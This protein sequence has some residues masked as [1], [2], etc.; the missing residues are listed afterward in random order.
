MNRLIL[1]VLVINLCPFFANA[2]VD[3]T[4]PLR[5]T[6]AVAYAKSAPLTKLAAV[7]S[8]DKEDA[9]NAVHEVKNKLKFE[10]WLEVNP[11]KASPNVQT[12]MGSLQ[13]RG[14]VQG[15]AGQGAT[16]SFPP[17]T[18]GDVSESHFIQ[19]V[20]SKYNVYDKLGNKLLGPLNLS[21]LWSQL[22]GPWQGTNDGDPI[23]LYDEEADR[24][25]ITQF[26]VF[27]QPKY[28]LFAISETNDP[29]GAY[30]LYSFSF[31]MMNDYPKIGVWID[32]YYATYNMHNNGFQGARITVVERDRML[33]G[34]PAAQMIEFHRSNQASLM[35]ADI[36]GEN[37]PE[38]GSPCPIMDID[39]STLQVNFWEFHTDWENPDNS[40]YSLGST[41]NVSSFS[42]L[43]D[44]YNGTGGFVTQPGTDQR[45]DGLGGMIMNRLAYRRFADHEAMVVTHSI[46]VN[47]GSG[48]MRAA[49]RW[50]EFRNTPS[51]W[52][53]FQEGTYSPD[54][55]HRWMG[56]AAINANGDIA[57]AYSVSN[58]V[59]IY[60]SIRY[61]GRRVNDPLGEMTIEEVEMKTGT[62]NQNH[63]R[64]GDYACMNVDP[65]DD[66][67][68]WFTTEYNGWKTWIASFNL[69]EI[70][71][72]TCDAGEDDF[73]CIDNYFETQ[74]TGTGVQQ[75]QWTSDGDGSMNFANQ[76]NAAYIRGNQ[77]VINGG[78]T[79]TL[80]VTG[81][82]GSVTSDSMFLSIVD[83]P[84]CNAGE[85]AAIYEDQSYT[86]QATAN[87][88]G[89]IYWTTNGDGVF[90]D[91]ALL[92]AIYTPGPND[93]SSGGV[94]L[95]LHAEP[96]SPCEGTD[97]DEVFLGIIA[98]IDQSANESPKLSIFPNPTTGVFTMNINELRF[99][100]PIT[101]F[102]YTSYGK[103]VYREVVN[104]YGSEYS[105]EIDLSDFIPGIYFISAT[106][107]HGTTTMKIL[108]K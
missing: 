25:I 79:L 9:I 34:D 63:W 101:L 99:E 105:K 61:T 52:A 86:L 3:E 28:E 77:D 87:Y 71:E 38:Q 7:L 69:G 22:P 2:Q 72:P 64:W 103:E 30:H 26:C 18:D 96:I 39:N 40:T 53:L 90:S 81:F 82:D 41:I 92:N 13:S 23:V 62:S 12:K 44:T 75:I 85:D 100:A 45:L 108:K 68:F 67:T 48:V 80:Q 37:L 91:Q 15:F 5:V 104:N 20:N 31:E 97:D 4:K 10:E 21:T 1:F 35:P 58:S 74:G 93:I 84:V 95:N 65:A 88:Y 14:P 51:G 83:S 47:S 57:I 78:C 43:P 33:V 70:S 60:P 54:N 102:V 94:K 66:T 29:L 24:W 27:T 89:S 56:S 32:G 42:Y 59:D 16:G 106:T 98:S 11:E 36:D 55:N 76:Y 19:V 49:V 17:D 107:N 50:Y 46:R 8:P 6:K 73:V